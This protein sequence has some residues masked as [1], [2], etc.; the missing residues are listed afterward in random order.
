MPYTIKT[1]KKDIS[2]PGINYD[3]KIA[4][5]DV[6]IA[7]GDRRYYVVAAD[8]NE[9]KTG[10]NRA[11]EALSAVAADVYSMSSYFES[12]GGVQPKIDTDHMLSYFCIS[13]APP[14]PD[15]HDSKVTLQVNSKKV[16]DFTLNQKTDK[17]VN[18]SVPLSGIKV[19]GKALTLKNYVAEL[20]IPT[21]VS[22]LSDSSSYVTQESL[23]TALADFD[24]DG[25]SL[26][27]KARCHRR[28]S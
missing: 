4:A 18:I 11:S 25:A 14:I 26:T 21:K 17:T 12:I 8:L 19:N 22:D 5:D 13:D 28:I 15:V 1:S 10:V 7:E 23:T 16:D 9:I 24:F 20:T 2:I 6:D 27:R 3:T